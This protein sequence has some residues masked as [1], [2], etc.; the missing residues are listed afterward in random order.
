[1]RADGDKRLTPEQ[2]LVA[3]LASST[4]ILDSPNVDEVVS[5][6][7]ALARDV[8]S[9]DGYALW[10]VDN[11]GVWRMVQSFGISPVFAARV[12]TSAANQPAPRTVPFEEPLIVEDVQTAPM[13]SD[14]RDAYREEGVVS[15]VVFPLRIRG[16]R[17]GTLVFYSRSQTKYRGVDVQVGAALANLAAASLTTAELYEEQRSA[18]EAAD[19]ARERATFLAEASTALSASLDYEATLRSVAQL[20]V[21]TIADWCAV[22][23]LDDN[24]NL[25]RL[26]VAHVD[27]QKVE[28]ARTLQER[29][30]PDPDAPGGVHE[31]ICTA[32][33]V[34]VPRIP[35][36]LLEAAARDD[37][38]RRIIRE[39]KLTS[40][41]CVP[42]IAHG[43]AFGA[44]T[45]VS[46]ESGREYSD[47]DM[48]LAKE[49]ASRASL[50]V[51]NA[52]AYA[53]A[54]ETS[55]V[56]DEFLSTLSHELRT[57]LGS[58]LTYARMLRAGMVQAPEL[59]KVF[60]VIERN[61]TSLKQIVEDVLDVSS[62]VAGRL[63][64]DVQEVDLPVVLREACA[65]VMPAANAKGV[66]LETI[67]DPITTSVSGDPSRLQQIVWNLLSNAIKFTSRGGKVQLRLARVN[68]HVEI[69]VS[70]TGVGIA[71]EFLPFVFEKF[72]QADGT[73]SRRYGGLGLGL[74]IAK[75]LAELH[76]GTIVAKSAGAGH[77]AT[78]VFSLPLMIVDP[79]PATVREQPRADRV[80]V[81]DQHPRLDGFVVLA[82]D[83]DPDSLNVI[84]TVLEGAGATMLT[85]QSGVAALEMLS[86]NTPDVIVADIGMPGMDGFQLIR[87][88]R[89][90]PES[91]GRIPAAALT[92]YARAQDR[93]TA[94]ASGFQMHLVKPIDPLELIVAIAALVERR[95]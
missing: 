86:K 94:L 82:V 85:A 2:R 65:T 83:D 88:I 43:K 64:L 84:K 30:P 78:F 15:M 68:S 10:R 34:M 27:P 49:V 44:I 4:A 16:E 1:M 8:F 62:I 73:F 32:E 72:R 74:A 33:A 54:Q 81:L 75:Q 47:R 45:F 58:V 63:R 23:I 46:A 31:V 11:E 57:P 50:A 18:R 80:P 38:H 22:D 89:R 25:Q 19:H 67:V 56:K 40:Y 20:A 87:A 76:G 26:A 70:D 95:K 79:S 93:V 91:V 55:R 3:L 77:G 9:S 7:I 60:E 17:R 90:L 37:E 6:T 69:T 12:I 52:R 21:P 14:M 28:L 61:A 29:Y 35:A 13:I 92:A 42:M 59:Q 39:L 53:L 5:S 24:G 41:M 51:E 36:E 66:R 71:P 48:P